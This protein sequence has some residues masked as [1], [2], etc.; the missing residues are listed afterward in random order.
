MNNILLILQREFWTRVKS[1]SF[2]LTTFLAP[3]GIVVFYAALFFIMSRGSDNVKNL[4][5]IDNAG[6]VDQS[7]TKRNNL[8]LSYDY[9][10]LETAKEAYLAEKIDGIIELPPISTDV[11]NYDI[12]FHSDEQLAIDETSTIER[13]YSKKVRNFKIQTLGIDQSQLDLIDTDLNVSP[14]TIKETAKDISSL[15]STV[16][17]VLGGIVGFLLFMMVMI[18]G[19]QVMRSV[20]EEKIN[21]I[22]EVLISSIKPF[23]LMMG[24]ILGVGSVGLLQVLIWAVLMIVISIVG[25]SILGI[26]AMDFGGDTAA[27]TEAMTQEGIKLDEN[28]V[29]V[30]KELSSI[31][32]AMIVPLYIF[33]FL[34][35]YLT[36]SALFAAVGS[37]MGDDIQDA[38]ALT[39]VATLPMIIAFYIAIAAVTAPHSTMAVWSSIL[40]FFGPVVMPVRLAVDPPMWQIVASVLSSIVTVIALTWLAGRI[41][42]IGILMYGKKASFKELGKWIFYNG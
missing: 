19:S 9:S 3:I 14:K 25:T 7:E 10:D 16:S 34:V 41:Y 37:A 33:Y 11:T 6:I 36:Y 32:W 1:K 20:S 30:M 28:V 17:S 38:Q 39:M 15:T 31:N 12:V 40:P 29:G 18:Y 26:S 8:T 4:A 23:Q 5:V 24:K 2:L 35:G 22:V 13:L 21:R 27:I 42:R